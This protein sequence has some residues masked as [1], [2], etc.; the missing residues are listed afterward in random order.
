M[1]VDTGPMR[2]KAGLVCDLLAFDP[3]SN[4]DVVIDVTL[5][6]PLNSEKLAK[7]RV[8]TDAV[9]S[10]LAELKVRAVIAV[11]GR[12]DFL[13]E[14]LTAAAGVAVRLVSRSDLREMIESAQENEMPSTTT[15]RFFS[16][17]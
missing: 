1:G 9:Q 12:D 2:G 13:P 8:R 11:P 15:K 14:E 3:Y 10:K 5:S 17:D 6:E 16:S 4:D 7:V